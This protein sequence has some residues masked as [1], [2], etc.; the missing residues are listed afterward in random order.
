MSSAEAVQCAQDIKAWFARMGAKSIRRGADTVDFQ[1]LEKTID[2]A[3]PGSL[4]AILSEIN[5]GV[6][7]MDK[8]QF[9]TD[10]IAEAY[11]R[12]DGTD[13]WKAGMVPFAGDDDTLLVI[14]TKYGEVS[15]WDA[16][17]GKGDTV[18]QNLERFLENYR[19]ELLSGH[20]EYL[21]DVGVIE[22]M[23]KSGAR[24]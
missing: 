23:G 2:S 18:A 17:G 8:R 20:Y 1:R 13:G 14:D 16:H 12:L 15:E 19:N 3:L 24:K 10:D 7:F 22:K 5:G 21:E 11:G 6:Y 4:K 9:S